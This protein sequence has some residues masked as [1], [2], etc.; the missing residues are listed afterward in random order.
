MIAICPYFKKQGFTTS[1]NLAILKFVLFPIFGIAHALVLINLIVMIWQ[2]APTAGH[3]GTYTGLY[4]FS[5][6]LAAILG[7]TILGFLMDFVVGI[8]NMFLIC[9]IFVGL[10]IIF[11]LK[12]KR[13]E[14]TDLTEEEKMERQKAI[15][16]SR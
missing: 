12:V 1:S 9:A 7:P 11:M 6:F 10:A 2:M 4:Y 14:P 13:G 15:E 8:G 16:E 3:I 5:Q